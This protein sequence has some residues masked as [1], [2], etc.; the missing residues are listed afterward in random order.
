MAIPKQRSRC[1]RI[2]HG[3]KYEQPGAYWN[4]KWN[5]EIEN[6]KLGT[7]ESKVESGDTY[8]RTL[9]R[10]TYK[11]APV[12]TC[13]ALYLEYVVQV[14]LICCNIITTSNGYVSQ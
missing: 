7:V 5:V 13:I 11:D 4:P 1:K 10:V 3:S 8:T 12:T 9:Y 14:Y 6:S 2:S